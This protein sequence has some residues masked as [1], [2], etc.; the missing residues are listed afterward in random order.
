MLAYDHFVIV[1]QPPTESNIY[2]NPQGLA[3]CI[4]LDPGKAPHHSHGGTWSGVKSRIWS[5]PE[6]GASHSDQSFSTQSQE[7]AEYSHDVVA[8]PI[9][10]TPCNHIGLA[11]GLG[12]R[13]I[14]F[15]SATDRLCQMRITE[16][17]VVLEVQVKAAPVHV[18]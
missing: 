6:C 9:S 1:P 5:P 17:D 16:Q 10:Q 14:F 3:F 11:D 8:K 15:L 2:A 13:D 4:G 7:G 18:R 12:S